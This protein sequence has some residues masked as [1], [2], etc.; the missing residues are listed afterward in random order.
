MDFIFIVIS[1]IFFLFLLAFHLLKLLGF[2]LPLILIYLVFCFSHIVHQDLEINNDLNNFFKNKPNINNEKV[3]NTYLQ[4][5][6]VNKQ[7]II[8]GNDVQEKKTKSKPIISFSP[9]PIIIDSNI[10]IQKNGEKNKI[11]KK[12][13]Q[14]FHSKVLVDAK[15]PEVN[16]LKI[17]DIMICR[18]VYKRNPIKPGFKFSN[19]VDSLFCYTKIS[20]SGVK[21]EIKHVWYYKNEKITSVVYNI[22]TSYNYRSWSR[23]NILPSQIGEWRVDIVDANDNVI[24]SRDFSISLL[25]DAY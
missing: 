1:I 9:K 20:N 4:N 18:G 15:I 11:F 3:K 21:K 23:K 7:N 24:G 2:S 10:I 22:K 12:D 14:Y 16:T 25:N 5:K 13:S 6:S 8:M 17:N 19:T